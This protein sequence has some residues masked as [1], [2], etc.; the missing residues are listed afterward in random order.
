M[1]NVRKLI[2]K[3]NI[4]GQVSFA[5]PMHAHT[6]FKIGGPAEIFI[7]P[8][9]IAELIRTYSFCV[10][11]QLPFFIL[12][13]GSNILVS[14]DGIKGIVISLASLQGIYRNDN[15][16][17]AL[18]GTPMERVVQ[19]ALAHGLA[20]L[21][22]FHK[23]PG[24]AGG[25][26]WMNAR[27]YGA[28]VSD[29]LISADIIDE[30]LRQRTIRADTS[31]FGY[32]ISP[33]QGKKSLIVRVRFGLVEGNKSLLRQRMQAIYQDRIQKG[34]FDHPSGG[35]IFKNNRRLGAPTG[36]IIDSMGLKGFYIGGARVSPKHANIIINTGTA[37]ASDVLR[38][39]RYLEEKVQKRYGFA[40]ERELLLVGNWKSDS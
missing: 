26:V 25:A 12:G 35:S 33:F 3:I 17:T 7:T 20:G 16:L 39:L 36:K 21:E 4:S 11:N 40:P 22:A 1:P 15:T 29:V 13:G 23:M 19:K 14:D 9:T 37:Q 5:E 18:S 27:C 32:K 28:S 30:N 6:S 2:K 24:T 38:L 10:R 34:H 31:D 8:R